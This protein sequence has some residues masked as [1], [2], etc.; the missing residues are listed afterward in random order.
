MV[1]ATYN[2]SARQVEKLRYAIKE[3][4]GGKEIKVVK[5]CPISY[6][7]CAEFKSAR[8]ARRVDDIIWGLENG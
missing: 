3:R 6:S 1:Q 5:R 2:I 4:V 7:I 8:Q